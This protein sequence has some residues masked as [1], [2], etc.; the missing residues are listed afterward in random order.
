MS[1]EIENKPKFNFNNFFK[2]NKFKILTVVVFAIF[3][4]FIIIIIDEYKKKQN[5]DISE[6]YNRA[7]ILIEKNRSLESLKLLEE[8]ILKKNIFYS[9]SALNLIIDNKMIEDKQKVLIYFEKVLS[10]SNLDLETKNLFT[11][12]KVIYI[13]DDIS[14]NDLL[15]SL[16]PILQSDSLWKNTVTDYI[17]KYYLSK[18]EFNKAKEFEVLK[19]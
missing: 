12:K 15:N 10:N 5:I 19:N 2:Q 8:I 1:E 14:E 9:P 6:K 3:S 4:V 7:K 13:G 17:K 18:G 16:K 11:F